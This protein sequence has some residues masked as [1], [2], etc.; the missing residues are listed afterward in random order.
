M[1]LLTAISASAVLLSSTSASAMSDARAQDAADAFSQLCVAMFVGREPGVDP[2]RFNVTQLSD[3]TRE[4]IK[5]HIKAS[6]LW[7]VHAKASDA[8]MLMHYDPQG[9]CVVEIAEADEHSVQRAVAQVAV[10]TAASLN[11]A[12]IIQ[13]SETRQVEGLTA[14]TLSWRFPSRG[15]DV[16]IMLTTVPVAKFMIQHVL[17]ISY[18]S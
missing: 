17:T 14:T 13:P 2:Q 9:I 18:V 16:L 11:T 6:T 3:A 15:N 12:A 7:D 8:S 4:Q 1:R 10:D 5:P